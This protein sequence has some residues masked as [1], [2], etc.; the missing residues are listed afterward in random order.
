MRKQNWQL[1]ANTDFASVIQLCADTREN[2]DGTWIT[3]EM[4]NAYQNLHN[5]GYAHSIEVWE[6]TADNSRTLVGGIY[7][8]GIG[9]IFSGES[10]FHRATDASKIALAATCQHLRSSG[11]NLLDCQ[12]PNKHLS[13]LGATSITRKHYA[14]CL[15]DGILT[16]G[17]IKPTAELWQ[18]L[19]WKNTVELATSFK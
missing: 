16:S 12:I 9:R 10:M 1:T 13:S 15:Q 14:S 7:G 19:D 6:E 2:S 4:L 18:T 8:V 17:G 3:P 11:W 5:A